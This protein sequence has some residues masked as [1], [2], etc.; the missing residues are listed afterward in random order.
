M[1]TSAGQVGVTGVFFAAGAWIGA[2]IGLVER[3]I[4][5]APTRGPVGQNVTDALAG[6]LLSVGFYACLFGL[7][8]LVAGLVFGRFRLFEERRPVLLAATL[9]AAQAAILYLSV[10][11]NK[12][13]P[14]LFHPKSL[15]VNLAVLAGA[16]GVALVLFFVTG[17]VLSRRLPR[18]SNRSGKALVGGAA[19]LCAVGLLTM[20]A[21]AT[22]SPARLALNSGNPQGPN[23]L[24]ISVD[25]LRADHLPSYGYPH[26]RTPAID[27][28]AARGT[29]FE[30]AFSTTSWTLPACATLMTGRTPRALHVQTTTDTLP[31]QAATLSE[32][33]G[34]AG[35]ATVAVTSNPFLTRS[36]GFDRGFMRLVSVFDRDRRPPLSGVYL[37]DHLHRLRAAP[38]DAAHVA[39]LVFEQLDDLAGRPFFLWLHFMDPHKPYGGPWPLE[40]PAYDRGYDGSIGFV[41]GWKEPINELREPLSEADLRHVRAL[42]DADIVRFDRHLEMVLDRMGQKGMLDNTVIALVSDHGEEFLEHGDF[43]HGKNLHVEQTRVPLIFAGPG[44]PEN[45]RVPGRV[46]ILNLPTTLCSLAGVAPPPTFQGRPLFP[47][48]ADQ[49]QETVFG[50]LAREQ[51]HLSLRY[52]DPAGARRVLIQNVGAGTTAL[53]D[54][55]RDPGETRN[56][57]A[58]PEATAAA[59]GALGQFVNQENGLAAQVEKGESVTVKGYALQNLRALGYMQ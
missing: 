39:R 2:L 55:D 37:F 30:N 29:L 12:K 38:D 35:R 13:L 4:R 58:E 5:A 54:S 50:E 56:L 23:V 49:D 9:A 15:A 40:L 45:L 19:A 10:P 3:V 16:V 32:A 51:R 28:I 41:Y 31:L 25:T 21:Y 1:Q 18:L 34:G 44:V 11:I 36:F 42:Y 22:I 52:T 33:M 59:I 6:T 17:R 7:L 47:L 8:G 14:L 57:A 46:S 20:A 53:F 43:E 24:L 48:M 27:R 26:I